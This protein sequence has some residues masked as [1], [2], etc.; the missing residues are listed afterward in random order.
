[1]SIL[2]IRNCLDPVLRKKCEPVKNIDGNL[3]TLSNDMIETMFDS[4]GVGLAANQVGIPQRLIVVDFGFDAERKED[5]N[6]LI[7]VNP[8]ITAA[9]EEQD[10]QEGCLSIPEI[11]ADVPR[12]KRVE[13]KGVDL[14]G[15][16][17]RYE[18]EDYLARAFQHELDHLEGK[19]FWDMLGRTKRDM[20][21]RKFKKL[22]KEQ[23]A[24]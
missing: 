23:G 20:L 12:F 6:P 18:V 7:I 17:V 1:M 22:L 24:G 9:E 14:D 13:V 8:I 11:V 21:K 19:L 2:N 10:G 3:V 16:D 15:N 5:H 4:V